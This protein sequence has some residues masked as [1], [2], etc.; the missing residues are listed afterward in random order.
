MIK[1]SSGLWCFYSSSF[2][3]SSQLVKEFD[4]VLYSQ[5]TPMVLSRWRKQHSTWMNPYVYSYD[6]S[7][8][9]DNL[10]SWTK[11][12]FPLALWEFKPK[13]GSLVYFQSTRRFS[14]IYAPSMPSNRTELKRYILSKETQILLHS[15][16]FSKRLK[17]KDILQEQ[18]GDLFDCCDL[19]N[20]IINC[21]WISFTTFK[22]TQNVFM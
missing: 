22:L 3:V 21:H 19:I 15:L 9:V 1:F 2:H 5:S 6:G 16:W 20:I 13:I 17:L 8:L 12:L 11:L 18:G 4:E 14:M 7:Y 10:L